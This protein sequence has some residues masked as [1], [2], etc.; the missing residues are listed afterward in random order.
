MNHLFTDIKNTAKT[1]KEVRKARKE[2][3]DR[4][5]I[6]TQP[7]RTIPVIDTI[8]FY[9]TVEGCTLSHCAKDIV[10]IARKAFKEL[11]H[12]DKYRLAFV[13][14]DGEFTERAAFWKSLLAPV[15]TKQQVNKAMFRI[16]RWY[17]H[18]KKMQNNDREVA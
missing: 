10:D 17:V 4:V 5:E 15:M 11:P 13:P 6:M 16:I 14:K 7:I 12:E 18:I 2:G 8:G 3:A 9:D 1:F